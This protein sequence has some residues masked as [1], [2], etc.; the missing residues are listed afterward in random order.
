MFSLRA[1]GFITKVAAVAL[2]LTGLATSAYAGPIVQNSTVGGAPTGVSF[3]NFD[4]LALGT[5]GGVS[6][7]ITVSFQNDGAVVQGTNNPINAAPF[8]SNNN[9]V[10]FGDPT[11]GQDAT[12]YITSGATASFASAAATLVFPDVELYMGLLWGSVD[13]YNTLTFYNAADV[14]IGTITGVDVTASANG[15][16]GVNGTF[17]VNIVSDVGFKKVVATSTQ[18]AFEFDNVAYN[19]TIPRVPEPA[20]LTLIGVGLLGLGVLARRRRR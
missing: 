13:L 5:A 6:N 19:P 7:G 10:P 1:L 3:T 4:N 20:T 15:N 12:H 16:Q 11:N 17:Y 14:V 18:H 8:L 9:G 2:A